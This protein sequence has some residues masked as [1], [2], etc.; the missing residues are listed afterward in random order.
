[1]NKIGL[2]LWNINTDNYL[3]EARNLY[4]QGV[5]DY[6][7]LY[8]VPDN[9]QTLEMWKQIDIPFDIH[10][11]HSA[12]SMNL[13]KAELSQSNKKLYD[14]VKI[15]ADELKTDCII[16]HGGAGGDYKETAGQLKSF[17]DD[18][19]FI[20]NKPYETLAFVKEDFY[21]GAK[22]EEIEYIKNYADCKFCL[23]IGHAI[24]AANALLIEPYSYI[25]KMVQ[26]K[27]ERIH[28]SDIKINT[29][30]D[31]HLNFGCGEIDYKKLLHIIPKG[32]N[33]TIETDKKSKE[34]LDDFA[35][36]VKYLKEKIL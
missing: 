30:M 22:F 6:I 18:R 16:F 21:V 26:L 36:D 24:C 1:M 3:K 4:E 25:E 20:E 13:S 31:E 35:K 19:I 33:I 7:E 29:T 15:F 28:L 34:N 5:F 23:D 8:I 9:L 12:H 32:I 27:P 10:A 2:K 11:P 14:E 17:N